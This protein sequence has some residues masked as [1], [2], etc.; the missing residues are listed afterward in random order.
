MERMGNRLEVLTQMTE[1]DPKN[2]F[3]RYGLAMEMVN[4]GRLEDAVAQF[5]TL[6]EH[7]ADYAAGYF[8]CG[9]TLEK[10]E[11]IAEARAVYEQGIAVT[12]RTGDTHAR[13][14]LQGALDL[15]VD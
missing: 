9:Q 12:A 3:A 2:A 7:N 14:E 8:H 15:L 11:R 13:S 10:L 1:A 4:L 5:R 6:L